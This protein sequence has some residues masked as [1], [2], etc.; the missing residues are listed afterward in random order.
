MT[1]WILSCGEIS[2]ARQITQVPLNSASEHSMSQQ[3]VILVMCRGIW[4]YTQRREGVYSVFINI[5]EVRKEKGVELQIASSGS[6]RNELNTLQHLTG[7]SIMFYKEVTSQIANPSKEQVLIN[8]LHC[9]SIW[10]L[11]TDLNQIAIPLPIQ[12]KEALADV[13]GIFFWVVHKTKLEDQG[14][15]SNNL[16]LKPS[17]C[18]DASYIWEPVSLQV[19]CIWQFSCHHCLLSALLEKVLMGKGSAGDRRKSG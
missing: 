18:C 12:A 10:P 1:S 17:R 16:F 4:N 9:L 7:Q 8:V 15:R 5:W 3:E 11:H 14:V 13:S 19:W 2:S 6:A